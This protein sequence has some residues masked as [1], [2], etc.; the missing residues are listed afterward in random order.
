M[1]DG[2]STIVAGTWLTD[3]GSV[4]TAAPD[5]AEMTAEPVDSAVS[6]PVEDTL[7]LSGNEEDQVSGAPGIAA[8]VRS[9]T[10]AVTCCVSPR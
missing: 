1:R 10:T 2:E 5:L 6:R 4:S 7:T 8:P 3:T 9:L